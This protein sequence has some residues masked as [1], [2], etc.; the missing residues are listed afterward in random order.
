MEFRSCMRIAALIPSHSVVPKERFYIHEI[1]LRKLCQME[2]SLICLCGKSV[3][4][5][6]R[7]HVHSAV[8]DLRAL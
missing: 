8:R 3:K 4:C 6:S 7:Q 2:K 5:V 1:Q